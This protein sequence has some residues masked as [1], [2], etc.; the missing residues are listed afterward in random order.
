MKKGQKLIF[1]VEYN[2]SCKR[3]CL[4]YSVSHKSVIGEAHNKEEVNV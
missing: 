2:K 4:M 3:R 1:T